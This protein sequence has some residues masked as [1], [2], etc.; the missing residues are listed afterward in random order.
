M[1]LIIKIIS[2]VVLFSFTLIAQNAEEIIRKAE[3]KI[4]GETAHGKFKMTVETPDYT[5][6]LVMEAWYEGNEKALIVIESPP[7]EADNKTLKI[8]NEMW[9]Y[10]SNTET[11][12]KVP[13]SMM[14]QSWNG[15]DFTNDDI[16]RESDLADDYKEEI[17][18][19]EEI[20]GKLC[21]VIEMIP[22]EDAPVVWGRLIYW[23]QKETTLPARV[24][25]YDEKDKL[26]RYMTFG[27]IEQMGGR[28][29]PTVWK[30]NDVVNEG[31]STTIEILSMEF[32]IN[33]PGSKFSF[34][35][36]ERGR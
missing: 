9:N 25:Y 26:M 22:N 3:D 35:E 34:R 5:R 31:E 11:T 15:S 10:L 6:E 36:L 29:I 27:K 12:I 28:K 21:W 4:K 13:P 33:I 16:V 19:E 18:G 32:N 1:K 24:E 20:D 7:K 30:M 14:L 17:T 23:V 2:L 8:G